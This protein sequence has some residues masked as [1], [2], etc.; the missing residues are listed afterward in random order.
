[1]GPA[2]REGHFQIA[3]K[4][5]EWNMTLFGAAFGEELSWFEF[6]FRPRSASNAREM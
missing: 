6:R 1:M 2:K 5:I 4:R 3:Q